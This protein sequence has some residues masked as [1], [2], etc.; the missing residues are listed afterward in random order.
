MLA[1]IDQYAGSEDFAW[2]MLS[3]TRSAVGQ[4]FKGKDAKA[5]LVS[6]YLGKYGSPTGSVYAKIYEHTGTFGTS[7]IPTG[8]PLA[9]S[10]PIDVSSLTAY[11]DYDMETFDWEEPYQLEREK[12]YVVTCE[13]SGGDSSN[14]VFILTDDTSPSH[15][16]N[17]V[18]YTTEWIASTSYAV[19]FTLSGEAGPREEKEYPLPAFTT[20]V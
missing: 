11:P 18:L 15:E 20:N 1:V 16:G 17:M 5:G 14:L 6:F 2:G 10:E 4:T 8:S 7:G 3:G 13:Y 12:D 9:T 19:D